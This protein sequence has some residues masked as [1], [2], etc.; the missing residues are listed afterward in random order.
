MSEGR[1][2]YRAFGSVCP[3]RGWVAKLLASLALLVTFGAAAPAAAQGPASC[4]GRCGAQAPSGCYCD[5]V[6]FTYND[7]C[8][9]NYS[10]C[11]KPVV[12]S[13]APTTSATAGGTL[14]IN[15]TN[16]VPPSGVI[17]SIVTIDGTP[18]PLAST[19][20]AGML[21]CT[22][23]AGQGTGKD[24]V[25][26][27]D[28]TN[29]NQSTPYPFSYTAP[30][31][32]S[33]FPTSGPAAGNIPI[34]ITGTNFGTSGSVTVGGAACPTTSYDHSLIHCTLPAG[35]AGVRILAVSV[36]GQSDS[37]DF[38]YEAP[39]PTETPTVTPTATPTETPT[40]TPTATETATATPTVLCN[41][42]PRS[43]CRPPGK[44]A[45]TLRDSAAD[46][47]KD[48]LV[49]TWTKGAATT[50]SDLGNPQTT[51]DYRFCLYD[52]TQPLIELRLAPGGNCARGKPCWKTDKSPYRYADS[53]GSAS[54]ITK[55]Q[56]KA[57]EAGKASVQLRGKGANLPDVP[58]L[59]TLPLTAQL[60]NSDGTCWSATYAG[61]AS[62]SE[63][64]FFKIGYTAP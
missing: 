7:C 29:G 36:A 37:T 40:G 18:C 64:D 50:V 12:N 63:P 33:V 11:F 5:S 38:T 61:P 2:P 31:V 27:H 58:L 32:I 46:D 23:P 8:S 4:V 3:G 17:N 49:W 62:K 14:T 21:Q 51:T 24:L 54:G 53:A 56:L 34:T 42:T 52:P 20:T 30:D 47:G 28:R 25:V 43:D 1:F 15:G 22:V 19:P 44:S 35:S 16:L 13:I 57:A 45:L 6:C 41:P 9:D 10:T 39:T 26:R 48:Q 55:L 59:P 60:V